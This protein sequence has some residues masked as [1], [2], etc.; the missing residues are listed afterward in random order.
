MREETK[1]ENF[2]KWFS[3]V[4]PTLASD[5]ENPSLLEDLDKHILDLDPILSWE[6]GP[7]S[8]EP[9]QLVISPN[10]DLDLLPTARKIVS[11][12]PVLDGWEFYSTR[13]PKNWDYK[14][15]MERSEGGE[16]IQLDTSGWGFVLLQYPDGAKEVLLRGK[17][18]PDLNDDERWQAAAMTLESILGEEELLN[19]INEFELVNQLEERFAARERPIQQLRQAV[20]G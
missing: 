3:G 9:L 14:L 17:N 12:A 6:I 1:I 7:G 20:L 16:T 4:A 8:S 19:R 13:R 2:W 18:I 10:L 15:L 11:A 5:V